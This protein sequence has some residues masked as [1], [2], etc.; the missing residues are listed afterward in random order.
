MKKK[1]TKKEVDEV[2]ALIDENYEDAKTF[3]NFKTPYEL[4]IAVILSA[5]CTDV[6]VNKVTEAL[7]LIARTP[8]E[9]LALGQ[10]KLKEII[11]SCGLYETKSKNIIAASKMIL[12]EFD[13]SVPSEMEELMRLPGVGRKTANVV[14][15]NAFAKDAI[16][17]DTHV[18]RVSNRIGITQAK[19]VYQTELQLMERIEQPMW[20]AMHHKLILHGRALC[21][22]RKP[23]CASCFLMHLCLFY[24]NEEK[25]KKN[26]AAQH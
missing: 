1:L 9:I 12:E 3:L 21:S 18:F 11:R 22:A 17:V 15:C 13:G 25:E 20:G 23:K 24:K 6:R 8:E 4:L 16:A 19:N 7:F 10:G 5:Q 2:I 14:M 26:T